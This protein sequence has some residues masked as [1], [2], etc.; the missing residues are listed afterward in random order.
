MPN[1][2][3]SSVYFILESAKAQNENR[4]LELFNSVFQY[5]TKACPN[6]VEDN[7]WGTLRAFTTREPDHIKA[8][9]TGNFADYGKGPT[10]HDLWK[11]FLGDSIFTT[12]GKQWSESRA[13]IRPMFIRDRI[14]DLEIFDRKVQTMIDLLGDSGEP[15]DLMDLFY[16]M[17]L[18]VTTEFLLGKGINSLENPQA[19]FVQAFADVQRIQMMLTLIGPAHH[20]YPRGTYNRGIKIIDGFVLPF[21]HSALAL[22]VEELEKRK[23]EKSFTFLHALASYTRDPQVIRDQV[24]SVLLAGRDTTAATLSWAFYELS[25]YP[26]IYAKLRTEIL[27]RV[28]PIRCPTYEDLKNM[29]YLCYTINET[30]RLYPAVPYNI[31]TAL[32]DTTLPTGGGPNGDLPITV[33]KGDVVLYSTLAMQRRADLYPPTS[34]TFADPGV[35]SPERWEQWTPKAWHYVPFNGGPRICIGQNFALAEIGFTIV[36][37]LQ[38]YQRLEYVGKWEEQFHKAEIVGTPGKGVHV[39]L[40]LPE[41]QKE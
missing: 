5:A 26:E 3:F 34:E 9:L 25:N 19:Q 20:L 11:P 39:R 27:N 17:T 4:L 10:F 33:L 2:I 12:D 21:V 22:P 18:D 24:V 7:P 31:R 30:L 38:R 6:C 29:P 37:I 35:F 1:N 41:K 28:G 16:R 13:L 40:F 32:A 23:S 14:S 15:V 8:V 36:R